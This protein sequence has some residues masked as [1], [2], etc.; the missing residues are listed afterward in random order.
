MLRQLLEELD[1]TDVTVIGN[2]IGGW[3]AAEV[4]LLH[5]PRITRL[6]LIDAVGLQ[7]DDHPIVDFFSFASSPR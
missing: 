4:A 1:L 6:V 2:S 5:S 7:I 3:I